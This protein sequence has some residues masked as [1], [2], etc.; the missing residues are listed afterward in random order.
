M[1]IGAYEYLKEKN[2]P[3]P[4]DISVVSFGDIKN[5]KLFYVKPA[6]ISQNPQEVGRKA[7]ELILSRIKDPS[8]A[9]R[10]EI[11]STRFNPGSSVGPPP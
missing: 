4:R 1:A 5:E 7:A 8:L 2:I 11:V 3:V 6:F 10:R 9:P